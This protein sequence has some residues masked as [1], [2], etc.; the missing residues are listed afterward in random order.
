MAPAL[1]AAARSARLSA[2]DGAAARLAVRCFGFSFFSFGFSIGF[3][4]VYDPDYAYTATGRLFATTTSTRGLAY[5]DDHCSWTGVDGPL[6]PQGGNPATFISQIEV[7]PDGTIFAAASSADDS[8]IYVSTDN[9]DNFTAISNPGGGVLNGPSCS[10]DITGTVVSRVV[11][12]GDVIIIPA[13][14]PHGWS[15]I[16][17]HV[18]Y[19]SVRPDP[20][21]LIADYVNPAVVIN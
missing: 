12:E 4:G 3:G 21:R 7:G 10:G 13:G 9:G 17:D 5:T 14:V 15:S 20:N 19:L 11:Y 6:G 16:P 1:G 2:L 8:H 18:D